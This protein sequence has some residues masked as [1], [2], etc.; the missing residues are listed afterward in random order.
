MVITDDIYFDAWEK[1]LKQY[2]LQLTHD[3]FKT[4]IAGHS[5]SSVARHLLSDN[6]DNLTSHLSI[7]KD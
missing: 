6:S 1:I 4:H 3:M 7:M 5:D 2:N